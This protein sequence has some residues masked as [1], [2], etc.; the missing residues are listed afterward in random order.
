M[1]I[2]LAKAEKERGLV[3]LMPAM[4]PGEG[5]SEG[6]MSVMLAC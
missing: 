2:M 3:L 1:L 6:L 5:R 4:G